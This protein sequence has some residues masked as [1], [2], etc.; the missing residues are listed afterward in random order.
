MKSSRFFWLSGI[1]RLGFWNFD[2]V[3]SATNWQMLLCL[4]I[5]RQR[6]RDLPLCVQSVSTGLDLAALCRLSMSRRG[7]VRL[8]EKLD[9]SFFI[10][11]RFESNRDSA[12]SGTVASFHLIRIDHSWWLIHRIRVASTICGPSWANS[13]LSPFVSATSQ[14]TTTSSS[15]DDCTDSRIWN[16]R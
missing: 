5:H 13:S 1:R 16:C 4:D 3:A 10:S 11:R 7:R 6:L 14:W 2:L 12:A 15:F 8:S 9:L